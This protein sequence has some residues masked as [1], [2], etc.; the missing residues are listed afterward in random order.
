MEVLQPSAKDRREGEPQ[1]EGL[2][3]INAA[4]A[5]RYLL[6]FSGL[7][8]VLAPTCDASIAKGHANLLAIT[9]M[10]VMTKPYSFEQMTTPRIA[11]KMSLMVCILPPPLLY[12]HR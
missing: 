3:A 10:A 11:S 5:M 7:R 8:F 1:V 12:H 6:A 2:T 4:N 9:R